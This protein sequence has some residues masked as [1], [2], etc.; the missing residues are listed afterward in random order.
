MV[1]MVAA[2]EFSV[3]VWHVE[4][5]L[6]GKLYGIGFELCSQCTGYVTYS[7]SMQTKS[8]V[9]AIRSVCVHFMQLL[10]IVSH[11]CIKEKKGK[12]KL[13]MHTAYYLSR[14]QQHH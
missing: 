5:I 11:V 10:K 8:F 9:H 2:G 14:I 12:E 6:L 13:E 4:Y 1:M 3:C 7:Y